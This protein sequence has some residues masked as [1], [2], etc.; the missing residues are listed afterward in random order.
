MSWAHFEQLGE[1]YAGA[2]PPYPEALY[3]ALETEGVVGPGVRVLEIGAGAGLATRELVRRGCDVVAVEPGVR[4]ASV[5]EDTVPG[6]QV[7]VARLEETDLPERAFDAAVAAT[8]LHWVDLTVGLPRIHAALRPGGRLAV[9]R[10]VF[11][12]EAVETPFRDRVARIV[13]ARQARGGEDRRVPERPTMEELASGGWFE[14]VRSE[15]WRRSVVLTTDQVHR[16][17]LTFSDWRPAEADAAA[18]AA[19]DLGGEVTEHYQTVL[20][21]LRGAESSDGG[22]PDLHARS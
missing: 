8:S 5:L 7:V 21:L 14:P 6:V 19:D 9:W 15:R 20:H 18:Q 17:F 10:T 11:R 22:D 16:L 2:R 3:D 12:D 1:E 4:L 13:A